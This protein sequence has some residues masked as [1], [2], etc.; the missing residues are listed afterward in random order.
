[1]FGM[2]YACL[3]VTV[4]IPDVNH[5]LYICHV[6]LLTCPNDILGNCFIMSVILA[7]G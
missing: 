4:Y 3:Y 2:V 1:M 6:N 5:I 7:L